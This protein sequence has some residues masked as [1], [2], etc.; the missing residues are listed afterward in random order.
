MLLLNHNKRLVFIFMY[1]LL[2]LRAFFF[3]HSFVISIS[4]LYKSKKDYF[5]I[6]HSFNEVIKNCTNQAIDFLKETPYQFSNLHNNGAFSLKQQSLKIE[7]PDLRDQINL[8]IPQQRPDLSEGTL[9]L[10]FI[11]TEEFSIVTQ[12]SKIF[13]QHKVLD[14]PL[15][16]NLS[17]VV[18]DEFEPIDFQK[19]DFSKVFYSFSP[20]NTPTSLWLEIESITSDKKSI[21]LRTCLQ[22]SDNLILYSESFNLTAKVKSPSEWFID[23][24][25]VD[26]SL[27][28]KQQAVWHGKD[29][30]LKLYGG[31][32]FVHLSDKEK[33]S[34]IDDEG[35]SYNCYLGLGEY[36]VWKKGRWV[37]PKCEE[38][39]QSLPLLSIK[40]IDNKFIVLEISSPFGLASFNL[41]L[42]KYPIFS[43]ECSVFYKELSYTGLKNWGEAILQT[44]NGERLI[45]S[46]GDWLYRS[47]NNWKIL[48]SLKDI[49]DYISGVISAPMFVFQKIQRKGGSYLLKG[50]LFNSSR[51][52]FEDVELSLYQDSISPSSIDVIQLKKKKAD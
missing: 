6:K 33:I 20:N 18:I 14:L 43:E 24:F 16:P 42:I 30:F 29:L 44:S 51:T 19:E 3:I 25:K 49:D 34:F 4:F 2:C 46:E 15:N 23:S 8:I 32:E 10:K 52:Y 40:R 27:L 1:K 5:L 36:V 37:E 21:K 47:S 39:T 7:P 35:I 9:Y 48:N 50:T 12:N 26:A 41:N 38:T 13:L 17:K 45:L 22:T 28:T 31:E 11:Q